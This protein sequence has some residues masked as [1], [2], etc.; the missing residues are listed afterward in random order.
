MFNMFL[1]IVQKTLP[2]VFFSTYAVLIVFSIYSV[3]KS[4]LSVV[5]KILWITGFLIIPFLFVFYLIGNYTK[6]QRI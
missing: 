4:N 6:I 1:I 5:N 3:L 2:I